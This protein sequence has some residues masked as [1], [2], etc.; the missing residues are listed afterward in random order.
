MVKYKSP[1]LIQASFVYFIS[2]FLIIV[3]S[4]VLMPILGIGTN[5]WINEFVY[6]LF[7]V[8]LLAAINKWDFNRILG[9]RKPSRKNS[10]ISMGLGISIWFLTANLSR[11]INLFLDKNVGILKIDITNNTSLIQNL[12]LIIGI[13]ILAPICEE[14]LFRG[15]IQNAFENRT[16]KY[17]FIISALLFGIFHI[18]NGLKEVVPAIIIGLVL[19]YIAYKTDSIIGSMLAH[20]FFNLNAVMF[21]RF[22]VSETPSWFN[23]ASIMSLLV[24]ILLIRKLAIE[25]KKVALEAKTEEA[26]EEIE[27]KTI[28]EVVGVVEGEKMGKLMEKTAERTIKDKKTPQNKKIPIT[29]TVFL[30]LSFLLLVYV[31]TVEILVRIR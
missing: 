14:T 19:S 27:I 31:G 20:A 29:A 3:G 2:I 6:I 12:L 8:I 9:Y 7:P 26:V 24:T 11:L 21:G 30:T 16:K 5:L 17:G 15:L 1:T 25:N 22:I 4:I 18:P 23:Y 13:V 10:I 28:D